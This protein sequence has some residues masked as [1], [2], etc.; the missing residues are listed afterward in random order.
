MHSH[1]RP[2][3]IFWTEFALAWL[4]FLL[5]HFLPS[6]GLRDRLI[7]AMGRR[8]Y[9]A[10]YGILSVL[11]VVW[12]ISA[13]ARAP[14]V[15]LWPPEPW[16]RWVPLLTMPF[17]VFLATCAIGGRYPFSLGGHRA[18]AFDLASPGLARLSRHPLPLALALWSGAHLFPNGDLAHVLLF[19]S[20]AA[21][22]LAAIPMFDHRA[23]AALPPA[24]VEAM[25]QVAPI[26]SASAM[27]DRHW[28]S[29]SARSLFLR[30][31]WSMLVLVLILALHETVIGVPLLP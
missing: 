19:G 30:V 3:M 25:F 14:F 24:D 7:A 31:V 12:L 18:G 16:T 9:F 27:F 21:L 5:S 1:D 26:L 29:A 10:I 22:G 28:L 2:A 4:V 17:A 23:R 11:C 13:A 6:L 8:S 15:E 20:F